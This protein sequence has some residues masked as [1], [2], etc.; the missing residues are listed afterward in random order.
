[1]STSIPHDPEKAALLVIDMQEFFRSDVVD[2]IIPSVKSIVLTCHKKGIPVLW[3]QHGH[4]NVEFD[5]GALARWWKILKELESIVS[6]SPT[7]INTLDFIIQSKTRYDAF[8]KTELNSFLISFGIKTLIISGVKTNLCCETTAR[9]AFDEN[10]NIV[11][12]ED[13]TATDTKEM[14]KATLL[15]IGYG[16]GIVATVDHTIKWLSTYEK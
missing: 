8:Y 15:N 10:Y 5:G 4:M 14:H 12:L 6:R 11:F 9:R 2:K 1:M 16:W 7:S 3:T 13:A